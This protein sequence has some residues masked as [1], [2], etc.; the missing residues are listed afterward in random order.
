MYE[1]KTTL[2]HGWI[3]SSSYRDQVI[4]LSSLVR[5][6]QVNMSKS[7]S[8]SCVATFRASVVS[9]LGICKSQARFLLWKRKTVKLRPTL[10]TS[11][12]SSSSQSLQ[13]GYHDNCKHRGW[14][15]HWWQEIYHISFRLPMLYYRLLARMRMV[16]QSFEQLLERILH[17][18]HFSNPHTL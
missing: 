12:N 18:F 8:F 9:H 6:G 17:L 3:E 4:L 14:K 1:E 13:E 7:G 2:E 11:D 5:I 15:K 10:G 16:R